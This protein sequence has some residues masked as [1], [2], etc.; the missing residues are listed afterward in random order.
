[1]APGGRAAR[2]ARLHAARSGRHGDPAR[3]NR[4]GAADALRTIGRVSEQLTRP[5][6]PGRPRLGF[7]GVLTLGLAAS[8]IAWVLIDRNDPVAG[9]TTTATPE[10]ASTPSASSNGPR[11]ATPDG[12]SA[13]AGL[14]GQPVFWIGARPGA[15]YEVTE[16]DGRVFVR[17]LTSASELGSPRADFLAVASYPSS[18][19]DA[20]IEAAARRPGAVTIEL[21]DG[22]AVYDQAAPTSVYLAYRGSTQQ[23]EVYSPSA[24]EARRIVESGL[25]QPVP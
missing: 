11:I 22:L 12:L 25:V 17:Y 20:D 2:Q 13:L 1:M 21:P 19:A 14:R 3:L 7:A 8:F 24:V 9:R 10:A 15:V 4:A 16:S 5:L 23:I 18:N 6:P